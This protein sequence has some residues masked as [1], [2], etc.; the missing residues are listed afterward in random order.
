VAAI[1]APVYW[2]RYPR[3]IAKCIKASKGE[4]LSNLLSNYL[5]P[6]SYRRVDDTTFYALR[7]LAF[8][9]SKAGSYD[10]SRAEIDD[11]DEEMTKF[12]KWLYG[13]YYR[14]EYA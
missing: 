10:R 1:E 11:M 2:G 13:A 5:P 14:R 9:M 7:R 3:N 4:E 8:V 12:L 6:L